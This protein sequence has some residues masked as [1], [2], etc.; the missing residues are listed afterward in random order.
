MLAVLGNIKVIG[1]LVLVGVLGYGYVKIGMLEGEVEKKSME[2]KVLHNT[3]EV[4]R[5]YF[6]HKIEAEVSALENILSKAVLMEEL[7]V[8]DVD[9][10]DIN[11]TYIWF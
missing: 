4:Q 5:E 9:S 11:S 8:Q 3:V 6:E 1:V 7:D 10:V 2:V